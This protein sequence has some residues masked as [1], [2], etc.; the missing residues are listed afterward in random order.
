MGIGEGTA[1]YLVAMPIIEGSICNTFS[2]LKEKKNPGL[3]GRV[4]RVTGKNFVTG[5]RLPQ[6]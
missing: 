3:I 1:P 2:P 4:V 5:N 6:R